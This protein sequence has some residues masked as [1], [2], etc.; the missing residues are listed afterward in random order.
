MSKSNKNA[1]M[2]SSMV[3]AEGYWNYATSLR[4]A[5]KLDDWLE[6]NYGIAFVENGNDLYAMRGKERAHEEVRK[7]EH[8]SSLAKKEARETNTI[9]PQLAIDLTNLLAVE[10]WREWWHSKRRAWIMDSISLTSA[11]VERMRTSQTCKT[12]LDVGCNIGFLASYMAEMQSLTAT[13]LDVA[14]TATAEAG[15]L[16]GTRNARFVLGSVATWKPRRRWDIVSAID[17]VQACEPH[18]RDTMRSVSRYVKECGYLVVVA[19]VHNDSSLLEFY[20]DLGF[21]CQGMQLTGGFQLDEEYEVNW[22]TKVGLVLRKEKGV[23]SVEIPIP[24]MM[25][26]FADYANS[27]SWPARELNRS[28]F[29][30][31]LQGN[32][33]T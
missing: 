16:A 20:R 14:E 8:L 12:L 21:S 1:D 28:Y 19:N 13:G 9:Q 7:Y 32:K 10:G 22:L 18:Y 5:Q 4:Q 15:K 26:D 23:D 11:V 31:R 2:P 17:L 29:L 30:A 27:G 6:C 25:S 3:F 24:D 33:S